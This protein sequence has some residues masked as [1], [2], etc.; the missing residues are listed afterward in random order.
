MR[1]SWGELDVELSFDAAVGR[2][3]NGAE[4]AL[5]GNTIGERDG[6]VCRVWRAAQDEIASAVGAG[7]VLVI[8]RLIP[9]GSIPLYVAPSRLLLSAVLLVLAAIVGCA[10]SLRRVLRVVPASA[11][12]SSS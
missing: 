8:D 9:P 7:M 11:L 3:G 2:E 1:V 4:I 5:D 6:A 12:G 10:F